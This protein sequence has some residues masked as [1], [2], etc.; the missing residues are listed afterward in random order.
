MKRIKSIITVLLSLVLLLMVVGCSA[1]SAAKPEEDYG[2]GQDYSYDDGIMDAEAYEKNAAPNARKDD[3]LYKA[4]QNTNEVER[5]VIY[6]ASLSITAKNAVDFYG[7][8]IAYG[9]SLG[10]YEHSYTLNNYD[11]YTQIYA[12]YKIPPQHLS[13]FMKFIED[14]GE[15]ISSSMNSQDI[16]ESYYDSELRLASKHKTL[17]QYYTLLKSAKTVEEIIYVQRIIDSITEDIE[18]LEGLLRYWNSQVDMVTVSITIRQEISTGSQ[19]KAITWDALTLDD[20]GYLIKRGF[21]AVTNTIFSFAQWLI[22]VL[23]GYSV[24]WIALAIIAFIIIKQRK[25]I[26]AKK[27]ALKEEK[28]A[29]L[30]EVNGA[31]DTKINKLTDK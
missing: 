20:M 31:D 17:E 4:G 7:N 3:S 6:N 25:K 24:V 21:Y 9:K 16:T 14:N 13:T 15:V 10:G 18:S 27:T 12:V 30:Q 26:L 2:K 23:V 19:R 1:K 11:T 8:V 22:I 5:K 28:K 29:K